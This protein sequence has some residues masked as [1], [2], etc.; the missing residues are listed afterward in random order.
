MKLHAGNR[1][2]TNRAARIRATSTSFHRF[3]AM[4]NYGEIFPG[5]LSLGPKNLCREIRAPSCVPVS[6]LVLAI[7][8]PNMPFRHGCVSC[9][10][11]C[12]ASLW[13]ILSARPSVGLRIRCVSAPKGLR[14]W[15]ASASAPASGSV[16][17]WQ[18]ALTNVRPAVWF[19]G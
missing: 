5:L 9:V 15:L 8:N 17:S 11:V 14:H 10:C 12:V 1:R 19:N 16:S 6:V 7:K 13:G 4:E 18:L 2:R 3:S